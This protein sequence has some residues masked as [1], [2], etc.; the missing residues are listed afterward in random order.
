[1]PAFLNATDRLT[2]L[3][4]V[5]LLL[6]SLVFFSSLPSGAWI[7]LRFTLLLIAVFGIAA[8]DHHH[9]GRI[10]FTLHALLPALIVPVLFDSLGDL[11]PWIRQRTYDGPLISI[12][13]ALFFGHHPTVL[14]ERIIHPSL[15][16]VLQA[17]YISYYPMAVVLG[18]VLL[19]RGKQQEFSEAVFGIVLCYYL[20]YIGYLLIPAVGPRYTLA[21]LQTADLQ[22]SPLVIA[23]QET[24]NNLE[25]TKTDAFPS[26][27]TAIALMTVYYAVTKKEKALAALLIP[28]VTGLAF[29]TVYLRY[30][31]VI[32]VLAGAGLA[33]LTIAISPRLLS[34]FSRAS[35]HARDQ[36][37][38][39]A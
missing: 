32:D 27:H 18:I 37:H 36:L 16:T 19:S 13:Y 11:I 14:L 30:H 5:L 3:F 2:V 26:G 38:D 28:I 31:Y 4:T 6:L 21:S 24:L 29:S 35:G 20:S 1:M 34:L 25:N 7:M 39:P 23:V 33:G 17:A 10:A 8:Y 15:T 22:A 9:R 12:D